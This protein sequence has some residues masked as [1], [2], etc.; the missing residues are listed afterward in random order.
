METGL[1][2]LS[3]LRSREG[4]M[5]S[6]DYTDLADDDVKAISDRELQEKIYRV[7]ESIKRILEDID[8]RLTEGGL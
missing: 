7:T 8:N 5:A 3:D 2:V 6:P 4:S 1:R